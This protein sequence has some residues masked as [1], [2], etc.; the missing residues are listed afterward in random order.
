MHPLHRLTAALGLVAALGVCA[1]AEERNAWPVVVKQVDATTG[2]TTSWQ[3]AGPLLFSEPAPAG[4]HVGGFRPFW[5]EWTGPQPAARE[6][7]FL[8]PLFSYREDA[9]TYSWSVFQLINR[10]GPRAGTVRAPDEGDGRE[11]FDVWPFWFSRDTGSPET[12]YR[13]LFPIAGD[14]KYHFGYE[15]LSW[16]LF[17][18]YGQARTKGYVTTAAPWPFVRITR[19]SEQGFSLWPLLGRR[20]KPGVFHNEY[21]LWPLIYNNTRQ[22][23]PDAPAGTPPTRQVAFLPFYAGVHGPGVTDESYLWPFF[24]FTDRTG[25]K[26]YHET[27][28][29]WPFFVQGEGADRTINRWAPFYTHSD[30]KGTDK[31]WVLWPAWRDARWV[32]G[33]IDQRRRQFLFFLYWSQEQR[34]RTNPQAAPA[35]KTHV[36]PLFSEWDN[37]AGRKQVQFPSPLEVFFPNNKEVRQTWTPLFALYRYNRKTPQDVRHELLWGLVSWHRQPQE[38]EFHLGPLFSVDRQAD[39]KRIAIGNG[40]VGLRRTPDRGWRLFWFDFKSRSSQTPAPTR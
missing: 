19:G 7:T 39:R 9:Q 1:R 8:Y 40:L 25:P 34:S 22:P 31:T 6:T 5:V 18:L 20:D 35:V 37:G 13:G 24:G 14:V 15:R 29:F 27:R 36:W 16:T 32:D 10:S 38:R 3:G 4:G 12:S 17:P 2:A 28:Y 23:A 11:A 26:R 30:I 21:Y 33:A